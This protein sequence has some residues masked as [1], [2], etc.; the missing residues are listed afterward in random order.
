MVNDFH[1][2][3]EKKMAALEG[4]L[5]PIFTKT[6]HLPE[7]AR[8]TLAKIAP[9]FAL[10]FG[11]LG[12]FGILSAG[13]IG[14]ML[15]LS[16]LGGGLMQISWAVTVVAGLFASVLELLAYKPLTKR[17]KKRWNYLFYGT[18]LTTAAA[19]INLALGYGSDAV[20]TI[21]GTVIGLWLL[22]EVRALYR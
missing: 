3:T 21:I 15:S 1:G 5:A 11:V 16:F 10:I 9:W 14:S 6:P 22:F 4:F 13:A 19:I 20:G 8:Q 18:V 12:I 2:Q 17:E 7:N